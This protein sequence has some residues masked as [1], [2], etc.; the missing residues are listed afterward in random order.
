V[1]LVPEAITALA[2]P[3]LD[4]KGALVVQIF[5]TPHPPDKNADAVA[6]VQFNRLDASL[7]DVPAIRLVGTMPATVY[8]RAAFV[9]D[10]TQLAKNGVLGAGTWLGGINVADGLQANEPVLPVS[11]TKGEGTAIDLPLTALRRLRAKVHASATPLDDGQGPLTV[12]A[13]RDADPT[14]KP[15]VQGIGTKKCADVAAGDVTVEGFV[16]GS[17]KFWAVGVLDDYDVKGDLPPG[18]LVS[19]DVTATTVRIPTSFDVPKAAYS[20]S[21]NI[22]LNYVTPVDP[23]AGTLT[24]KSCA[25]I[26]AT[27]GDAGISDGG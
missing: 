9:D 1:T 19:L 22:D 18:S 6:L 27:D 3:A 10:A 12:V 23:D 2:D 16:I 8:V 24:P 15:P 7:D 17:G 26:I 13:V 21:V 20:A 4:K 25:E 11:V 5:D 14:N